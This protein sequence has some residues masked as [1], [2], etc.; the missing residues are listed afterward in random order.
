MR[1]DLIHKNL[2]DCERAPLRFADQ[3]TFSIL[4]RKSSK[5]LVTFNPR[6]NVPIMHAASSGDQHR[7]R[8]T[9]HPVSVPSLKAKSST[10]FLIWP[11]VISCRV[12][13]LRT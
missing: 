11:K 4:T 10:S 5:C 8:K 12:T 1:Y 9:F 6:R 13:A 7:F 2:L 3:D